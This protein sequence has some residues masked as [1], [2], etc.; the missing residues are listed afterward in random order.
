MGEHY[1]AGADSDG[2]WME[3]C[4]CGTASGYAVWHLDPLYPWVCRPCWESDQRARSTLT[5]LSRVAVFMWMAA[6]ARDL[7]IRNPDIAGYTA[8]WIVGAQTVNGGW[9][10]KLDWGRP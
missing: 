7:G 5:L 3:R 10:F 2:P 1:T 9:A 4:A 6:E 8:R